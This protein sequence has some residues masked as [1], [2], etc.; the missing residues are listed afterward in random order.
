M[1]SIVSPKAVRLILS[2]TMICGTWLVALPWIA[3]QPAELESWRQLQGS[4][5]DPSAMYY[6]ELKAMEPILDRLNVGERRFK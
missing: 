5:I 1:S 4:K 3:R 6:S 2:I